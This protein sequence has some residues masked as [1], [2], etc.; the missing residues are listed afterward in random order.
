M[1]EAVYLIPGLVVPTI[2]K[3]NHVLEDVLI[4]LF[5]G[6]KQ[7]L[8]ELTCLAVLNRQEPS[9]C[10]RSKSLMKKTPVQPPPITAR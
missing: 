2:Q 5:W 3:S 4:Q 8:Q 9:H 7:P 6:V 10:I 1:T